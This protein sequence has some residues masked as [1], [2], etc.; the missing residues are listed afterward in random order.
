MTT[1]PTMPTGYFDR[2]DSTKEYDAHLFLAGRPI[3]SAELNE[4]QTTA[5]N[6]LRGVADALFAEGDIIRDAALVVDAD[7]GVA[8]CASGAI[9]IA[10][11]VRGVA[12]ATFTLPASGTVSVGVRLISTV[13]NS[14]TD[15]GLL[16]P[17][18]G[19]RAYNKP[20]AERL[21][22]HAQWGW[23][24]ET[25][26]SGDYYPVYS[27]TDR[28]VGSKEAP[29]TL[30]SFNQT[31]ARYD[32]DSAGG[33]YVVQGLGVS[34]LA[35][36]SNGTQ[37]YSIAEGRARVYGFG[38]NLTTARRVTL[39][40]APD[41]K[42]IANEPHLSTTVSAQRINFDR[43]PATAVTAV[44]IQKD[45]TA[46][47]T[48][49][50]TTGAQDPLPDTSVLSI[51]SVSQGATTYTAGT[52]YQL[53]AGKVDWSPAGTEPA[54]GSSYTV[55]YRYITNVTPTLVDATG[56]TVTGAAVGTLVQVSYSQMLPR[57]DRLCLD[58][59][60]NP[61]W[62]TGVAAEYSP[63]LPTVPSDLLPLASVYQTWTS[64]RYVVNDGVRV[65]PMPVLAGIEG[66]IDYLMQRIAEQRL[67]S[68]V[69]TREAGAKKGLF[70]DPFLDDSVRDAG[71][72][73]TAAIVNGELT[74]PITPTVSAV[75]TDVTVPTSCTYTNIVALAQTART[76]SMLINPYAAFDPVPAVVRLTPS[77]DRWTLTTDDW[78]SA[79]T[80]R[81]TQGTGDQ[82][83]TTS[84]TTDVLIGTTT[85][86]AEQLRSIDV[87]FTLSGFGPGETLSSVTF[88]GVA[89]TAVAP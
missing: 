18:T 69:H 45:K 13:V 70:V 78:A 77:V 23:S 50:V 27:V 75:S 11:A 38:I 48:H 89:V 47:L 36:L 34:K 63:L 16:D 4:I 5:Q 20:G 29:P 68:N 61:V 72:A 17:A 15:T 41:L 52:D 56:L 31:L 57:I 81:F 40:T 80:S 8:R 84:T 6:R 28:V 24:G 43:T 2:T 59:D 39:A 35:D 9:Y 7:T 19:T 14:T 62:L 88:D 82:S 53:T 3:Q 32:R 86:T 10:G 51:L 87:A 83:S 46:T 54:P 64:S 49:G 25:G 71:T 79:L 67:E 33:C 1:T 60:G 44:S 26:V 55:T 65:V 42:A 73:Q 74:L 85:E 21:K 37:A 58:Q 22:V 12:P 76:G 66:R 30:D